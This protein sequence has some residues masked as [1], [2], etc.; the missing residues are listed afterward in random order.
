MS[1]TPHCAF[2]P[3]RETLLSCS[4]CERPACPDCLV[5]A[6]VGMR[7]VGCLKAQGSEK[8]R[9]NQAARSYHRST[10]RPSLLFIAMVAAFV[11]LCGVLV[12]GY[13]EVSA[14]GP[15]TSL[16]ATMF[17]TVLLGWMVSLCLHEWAHAIVAFRSG[18]TSVPDKGYLTLDPRRY[19]HPLLSFVIPL[20]ILLIGGVPL[21]GGAVWI[22]DHR[23]RSRVRRALVSAAG[24]AVNIVFGVVCLLLVRTVVPEDS[25]L[26]YMLA[27]LGWIQLLTALLNLLPI[28]GLDGFGIIEP[29]LPDDIQAAARQLGFYGLIILIGL[30]L[31]TPLGRGLSDATYTVTGALGVPDAVIAIGSYLGMP[32]LT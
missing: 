9:A 21:P 32:R 29:F 25:G 27:L 17:V 6:A 2:H 24:P 14:I 5:P 16:K 3:D 10:R 20:G 18:D 12:V 22:E 19:T 26:Q 13:G 30:M 11:A 28:P 1:D 4:N 23:I 7:C 15:T 31:Y 8:T